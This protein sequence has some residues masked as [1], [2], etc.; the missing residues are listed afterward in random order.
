MWKSFMLQSIVQSIMSKNKTK[1]TM[2]FLNFKIL[3]HQ[4]NANHYLNLQQVI[5]ILLVEGV[6]LM[7]IAAD[8][9]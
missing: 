3:Y 8:W 1:K 5:I 2:H 7:L 4:K 9:S 6:A